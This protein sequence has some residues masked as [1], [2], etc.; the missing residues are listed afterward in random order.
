MIAVNSYGF[1]KNGS[2][3]HNS[4]AASDFFGVAGGEYY[5]KPGPVFTRPSRQ[6]KAVHRSGHQ[7]IRK[8][9]IN[10]L[11]GFEAVV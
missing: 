7:N 11:I 8:Y 3:S 10:D 1:A 5:G 4:L 2:F 9:E 6:A